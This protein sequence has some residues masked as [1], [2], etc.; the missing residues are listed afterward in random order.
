[1]ERVVARV[2]ELQPDL[3]VFT[4]DLADG[5][6]EQLGPHTAALARLTAPLGVYFCTGNHEYYSGVESWTGEAR[7]LGFDVLINEGRQIDFGG[8]RIALAGTTDFSAGEMV[9]GP[10]SD[11][12]R[13]L[14]AS[15][16]AGKS[17]EESR[18]PGSR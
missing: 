5:T 15:D 1:M 4:G 11:P 9:P 7:R 3:I 16:G 14:A 13:A 8:G 2:N 6:V 17:D 18:S 12:A 10:E